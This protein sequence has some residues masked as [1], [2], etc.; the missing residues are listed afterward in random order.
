MFGQNVE[1][2]PSEVVFYD[3]AVSFFLHLGSFANG[4][5]TGPSQEAN[6][7]NTRCARIYPQTDVFCLL[8][9]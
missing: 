5:K 3:V 2:T 6:K 9:G 7:K 4:K 1:R 8:V